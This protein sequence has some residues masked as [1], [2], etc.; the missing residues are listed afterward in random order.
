MGRT[1]KYGAN[2]LEDVFVT[3]D[4]HIASFGIDGKHYILHQKKDLMG[5]LQKIP[6][7][8]IP[9]IGIAE[10]VAKQG[11]GYFN[12]VTGKKLFSGQKIVQNPKLGQNLEISDLDGGQIVHN[13][14]CDTDG[15]L[16]YFEYEGEAYHL[17]R[18]QVLDWLIDEDIKNFATTEGY[19]RVGSV[20]FD[21]PDFKGKISLE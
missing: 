15:T 12:T 16:L 17:I 7:I 11:A 2:T 14:E 6:G 5:W 18:K 10:H 19:Y 13:S 1:V 20:T 21:T 4:N 8:V 3:R 9:F